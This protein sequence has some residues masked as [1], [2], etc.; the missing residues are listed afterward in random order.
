MTT[1]PLFR[2]ILLWGAILAVAIAVIGGG[3][4][5]AVGGWPAAGS[6]LLGAVLSFVFSGATAASVLLA[7]RLAKGDLLHPA[8]FGVI[9]AAFFVKLVVF[10]VILLVLGR[11]HWIVGT[12][13]VA[14]MFVSVLGGLAIDS[15]V[16]TRSRLGRAID[17]ELPGE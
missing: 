13:L 10:F 17:V 12:A 11:Q 1:A 15:L 14:T 7:G 5:W 4:A 9:G 6:A 8:F 16:I 2:R 3:I